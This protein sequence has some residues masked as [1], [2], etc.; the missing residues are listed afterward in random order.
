MNLR[1]IYYAISPKSRFLVRKVYYFPVDILDFIRG[2][3]N[4]YVPN[5]GDIFIGSGDFITQ[6]K[7]HLLLLEELASLKPNH[8]VLDIGCGIG[9]AAVPLTQFLSFDGEYE[10]FDV[11]KKGIVWCKKHISKD[12][13]NFNFQYIA[14]NNDL[15]HL[16]SQ[17]A[18]SFVF[19]YSDNSFDVVF[20]F[21]VFTHMQPLEVQNYLNEIYRVLKPKGKCLATFFTYNDQI[22]ENISKPDRNFN[23]QYKKENYRLM[24]EKVPSANIAFQ[25]EYLLK[26][27]SISGLKLESKIYGSW[28]NRQ[29]ADLFDYQDIFILEKK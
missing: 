27:I 2:R 18:E 8:A 20:L 23:F 19:P 26:M 10:G 3:K 1:S 25:E 21:S 16:T 14:L 24:S 11:V 28:A 5:K 6:G 29:N 12:F 13:P 7:H 17:Q 15:Y 22:E 4:K 9:R